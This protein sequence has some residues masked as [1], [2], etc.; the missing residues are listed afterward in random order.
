[1]SPSVY[2]LLECQTDDT[3]DTADTGDSTP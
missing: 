1:V 2:E 3:G